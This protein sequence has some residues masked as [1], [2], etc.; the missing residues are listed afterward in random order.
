MSAPATRPALEVRGLVKRYRRGLLRRVEARPAVDGADLHVLPGE[1]VGLVGESG[2]GKTTLVTAAL[3]L[4][5]RDKGSATV[6]G[7]AHEK[8]HSHA[9]A[10][11]LQR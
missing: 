5:S 3:G 9:R 4:I 11:L 7:G 1:V 2:S 10:A 8:M 6:L